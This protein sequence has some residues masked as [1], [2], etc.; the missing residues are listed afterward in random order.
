M[1]TPSGPSQKLVLLSQ[2]TCLRVAATWTALKF[3][4]AAP[5]Y[6]G[7]RETRLDLPRAAYLGR[8][9]PN[10]TDR[11]NRAPPAAAG[12]DDDPSSR[13]KDAGHDGGAEDPCA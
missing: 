7:G 3:L 1:A 10:S 2:P 9:T 12:N 6:C 11:R 5:Q 4:H 8:F 13:S